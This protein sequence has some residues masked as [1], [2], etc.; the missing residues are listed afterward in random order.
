MEDHGRLPDAAIRVGLIELN[1]GQVS[2][3]QDT[4]DGEGGRVREGLVHRA[5]LDL[6]VESLA[7]LRVAL[8]DVIGHIDGK[9]SEAPLIE[10]L[11]G[12]M[13][14]RIKFGIAQC[15]SSAYGR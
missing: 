2:V 13:H 9:L 6:A 1:G 11:E 5:L 12:G 14:G 4:P 7:G 15:D 10:G 3:P 8:H